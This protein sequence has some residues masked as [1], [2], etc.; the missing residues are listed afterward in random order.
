LS[1]PNKKILWDHICATLFSLSPDHA[2][3]VAAEQPVAVPEPQAPVNGLLRVAV[4]SD[5][6]EEPRRR[7]GKRKKID[8][9]SLSDNED[10]KE[11]VNKK[12]NGVWLK[13]IN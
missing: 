3:V 11:N 5:V 2:H 4:D 6:E 7:Y 9:K 12:L 8:N 13:A 10:S 1:N